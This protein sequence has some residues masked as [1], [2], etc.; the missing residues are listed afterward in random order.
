MPW[1]HWVI[2]ALAVWLAVSPWILGFSTLNLAVWN[3]ILVG[4]LVIVAAL[5][6]FVPP[7]E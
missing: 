2:I 4:G 1:N 5:W 7:E 3:N 6:N